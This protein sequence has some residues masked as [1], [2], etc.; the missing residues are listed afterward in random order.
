MQPRRAGLERGER[1]GDAEPA[2][3]VAVPVDAD[4]HAEL[5]DQRLHERTTAFAPFGV[6][7]PTVSAMHRRVAPARIAVVKSARSDP[8]RRASCPR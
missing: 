6:A 2:V 3:A 4:V 7:C 1:V 5:G 8:G